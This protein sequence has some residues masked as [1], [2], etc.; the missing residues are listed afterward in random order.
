MLRNLSRVTEAPAN[1]PAAVARRP[2][3]SRHRSAT[4]RVT[5]DDAGELSSRLQR[6]AD[7][8]EEGETTTARWPS[9]ER[10]R[11]TTIHVTGNDAD[12][13]SSRL[14]KR[15]KSSVVGAGL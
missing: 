15:R 12:E 6:Q 11:S 3:L 9:L 8:G 2:S 13:L 7:E 5:G 10:H 14:Q 1:G 4:V